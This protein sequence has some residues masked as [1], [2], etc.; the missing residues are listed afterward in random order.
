MP[1]S[2]FLQTAQKFEIQAYRKIKRPE[3]LRKNH[4]AFTGSPWKHPSNPHKVVL[5]SDPYSTNTHYYEFATEDIMFVEEMPNLA[6][7]EGETVH[8][9]RIWVRKS[10]IGVRCIP[11]LVQDISI[12]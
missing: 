6:D 9:V 7:P 4:V 5:V 8:M 12:K 2:K 11:F 10:S 3:D 1:M